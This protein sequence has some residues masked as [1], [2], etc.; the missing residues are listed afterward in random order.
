[1]RVRRRRC[2]P[3]CVLSQTAGQFLKRFKIV[4]FV[5]P[6]KFSDCHFN[7]GNRLSTRPHVLGTVARGNA[8]VQGM[9]GGKTWLLGLRPGPGR[10]GT[11]EGKARLA[12]PWELSISGA[13]HSESPLRQCR[14]TNV[15]VR[16][17]SFAS[18]AA[19]CIDVPLEAHVSVDV[20]R[21]SFTSEAAHCID[22]P[23]EAYVAAS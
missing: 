9:V 11:V 1:M 21:P 23:R 14:S 16:R 6:P 22:A 7:F 19:R 15:D 13:K 10:Q 3:L 5:C 12:G 8:R 18:K 2:N 4:G 17:H 20:R